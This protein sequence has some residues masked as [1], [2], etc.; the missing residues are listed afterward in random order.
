MNRLYDGISPLGISIIDIREHCSASFVPLAADAQNY[1]GIEAVVH[2]AAMRDIMSTVQPGSDDNATVLITG[3][4]G[5]GKELSLVQFIA[6]RVLKWALGRC[7][8]CRITRSLG[9]E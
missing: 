5:T 8:L 1:L 2:S 4:S 3:E 6:T 9:R 7:E